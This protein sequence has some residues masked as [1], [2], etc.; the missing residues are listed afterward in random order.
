MNDPRQCPHCGEWFRP[1]PG[2]PQRCLV[3][4]PPGTCCHYNEIEVDAPIQIFDH[5][6]LGIF[7]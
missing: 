5:E 3:M 6:K 2:P 4:H 1:K 7:E